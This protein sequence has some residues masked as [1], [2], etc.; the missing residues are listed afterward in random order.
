M[1]DD[2]LKWFTLRQQRWTWLSQSVMAGLQPSCSSVMT[3]GPALD[4]DPIAS[5]V[6]GGLLR[7][8]MAVRHTS[9][10]LE[11]NCAAGQV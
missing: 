5:S 9:Q 3:S 7:T 2:L 10:A 4:S 11:Q 1:V 8:S 6:M